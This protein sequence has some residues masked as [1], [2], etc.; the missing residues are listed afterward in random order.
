MF[1]LL[2]ILQKLGVKIKKIKP[3]SYLIFGKGLG[4]LHG[5]KNL[6]LNFGNSGTLARLLI[7]ILSTTP[8]IIVK[9]KGD[10]SLNKRNMKQLINLMS[11][12]GASF[13]PKNKFKFPLKLTSTEMPICIN[14]E[15]GV[16]VIKK[17]LILAGLNSFGDTKIL[18]NKNLEIIRKT[19]SIIL[20]Q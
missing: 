17:C 14:Y 19:Y 20:N 16:S 12:F 4:S 2:S 18:K 10:N 11:E 13:Y 7:G 3:K 6:E 8:N 5:R 15:A 1:F 9:V